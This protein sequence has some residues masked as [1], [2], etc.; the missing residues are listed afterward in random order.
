MKNIVQMMY[1]NNYIRFLKSYAKNET[2][3]L[4]VGVENSIYLMKAIDDNIKI[5]LLELTAND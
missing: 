3:L 1:E 2:T 5:N 4:W